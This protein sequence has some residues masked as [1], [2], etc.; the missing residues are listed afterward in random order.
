MPNREQLLQVQLAR[1]SYDLGQAPTGAN[2]H[3]SETTFSMSLKAR[4]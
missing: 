2:W 1:I 3:D 4:F